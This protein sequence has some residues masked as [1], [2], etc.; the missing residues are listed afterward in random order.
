M[1]K[2]K[3]QWTRPQ[4][5]VLDRGRPEES[6]LAVCKNRESEQ[7][8]PGLGSACVALAGRPCNLDGQS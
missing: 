7:I 4:L 5:I 1:Q 8:G 3:K 6:V 2:Q